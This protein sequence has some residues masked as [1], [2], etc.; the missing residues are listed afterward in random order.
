MN[1]EWLKSHIGVIL[2]I[3]VFLW[4]AITQEEYILHIAITIAFNV[5]MATSMWLITTLGLV[6]FAHAGFMGI[7][8]YTSALLFLKLGW[9]FGVTIWLGALMA[10]IIGALVSIPLMRTRAVYFFM[11]S[12]AL[13]EIIKMTFAYF[14]GTFGGWD[15]LFYILPPKVLSSRIAYYY[16]AVALT[17]ACVVFIWK[18]NRSRV[19]MNLWS[20]HE[21][22]TLAQHV[23]INPLKYKVLT[24]SIACF[25][26]GLTGALYAHYHTYISPRSFDI[27]QSEFSLV[28][29]IVGGLS[30]IG[31]PI[32]G[33][34]A[35]TLLDEL[36]RPLGFYRLITFGII[37]ILIVLF[38]PGGLI[39]I[40]ERIRSQIRRSRSRKGGLGKDGFA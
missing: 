40:P 21:A 38:L 5:M 31:G 35:L 28:H 26:A 23:G 8:A 13:G 6:S 7:G 4:P 19:G 14:R 18:L 39:S 22:E 32:V 9:P 20:I 25:W 11:A 3:L 29:N 15:G 30:A 12:W 27:W 10:G 1:K 36:F 2:I 37:L 16:V 17:V 24:F 33:A 34:I